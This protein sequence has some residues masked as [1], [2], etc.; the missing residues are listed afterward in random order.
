[1]ISRTTVRNH[2][3]C[4]VVHLAGLNEE[5]NLSLQIC[6]VSTTAAASKQGLSF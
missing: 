6:L 5:H 3:R 4:N 1:M 2:I